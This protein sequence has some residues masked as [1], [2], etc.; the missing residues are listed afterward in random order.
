VLPPTKAQKVNVIPRLRN[1]IR[2][3]L[4]THGTRSIKRLLWNGEFSNGR[5]NCLDRSPGDCVYECVEQFASNGSILDLGCGSGSTA[6]ELNIGA[7]RDYTGI[8][9]SDVAI[10]KAAERTVQEC[11]RHKNRFFQS[12][13]CHYEPDRRFDVILLRD[14]IY[15]VPWRRM[16]EILE[17]Y[18]GYLNKDG[19]II[20]RLWS[21]AGK[22]REILD[23]I[24]K[25]FT[26]VEKYSFEP[27]PVV[28]VFRSERRTPREALPSEKTRSHGQWST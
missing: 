17:R 1:G 21:V 3:F 6:N 7:Y 28:I 15:Y 27:G 20:V 19:V 13:I 18:S 22:Y 24:E 11:R 25:N 10:R 26:V 14:S 2:G 4:Q 23:S 9:I 8:D 16:R 5:W 12:D